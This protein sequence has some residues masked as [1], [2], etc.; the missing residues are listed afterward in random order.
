MKFKKG[1]KIKLKRD[2]I[3]GEI[4]EINILRAKIYRVKWN[5]T[6]GGFIGYAHEDSLTSYPR[7]GK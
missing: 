2:K 7:D 3:Y 1:D 6:T 4:L 5:L